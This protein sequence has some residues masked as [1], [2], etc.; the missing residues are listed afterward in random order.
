MVHCIVARGYWIA[1]RYIINVVSAIT[2]YPVVCSCGN[3]YDNSNCLYCVSSDCVCCAV[4]CMA[5]SVAVVVV[6]L[7][8]LCVFGRQSCY[9]VLFSLCAAFVLF[10][11]VSPFGVVRLSAVDEA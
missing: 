5:C 8:G 4:R 6:Y 3:W 1:L 9:V 7:G 10:E 11:F 2:T